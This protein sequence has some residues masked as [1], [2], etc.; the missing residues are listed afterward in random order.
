[1]RVGMRDWA[2]AE[3][4]RP[5]SGAQTMIWL[6]P[7][8]ILSSMAIFAWRRD[9]RGLAIGLVVGGAILLMLVYAMAPLGSATMIG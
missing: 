7:T 3:M 6:L 9:R 1:M 2:R 5:A 4:G 8:V